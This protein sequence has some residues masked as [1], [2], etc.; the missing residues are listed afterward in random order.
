[1]KNFIFVFWPSFLVAGI[2]EGLFFTLVRPQELYLFGEPVYFSDTATYSI[3]F[4]AF[5]LI[6]AS[7]SFL[8]CYLQ[9]S[10]YLINNG[11]GGDRRQAT[12]TAQ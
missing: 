7:S 10:P 3:G 1:M 11:K 9:R 8:T 2:A 12:P 5:W 4:L 6:C